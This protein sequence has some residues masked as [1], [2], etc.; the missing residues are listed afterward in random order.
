MTTSTA[1]RTGV[2]IQAWRALAGLVRRW[3]VA[4]F[5]LPGE[6]VAKGR[7][8]HAGGTTYTPAKTVEAEAQVAEAFR[9]ANP[10]WQVDGDTPF[11]VLVEFHVGTLRTIDSD[12]MLKLLFD[13]LNGVFWHDDRQVA[14]NH[15][16]VERG[17]TE[18]KTI[19]VL[20]PVAENRHRSVRSR[21]AR[22]VT[23]P[24]TIEAPISEGVRRR[25]YNFLV[26]E[27]MAGRKPTLTQIGAVVDLTPLKVG[28]VVRSLESDGYLA[29]SATRPHNVKIHKP[30]PREAT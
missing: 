23:E 27:T 30:F 3:A 4:E 6:P 12:N 10:D 26:T 1:G 11:G 25:V 28:D 8:R 17:V 22:P 21:K 7:P 24:L 29:R 5:V 20:F 16:R 18:P 14:E 19:V 9:R 2:P 13:G 15:F